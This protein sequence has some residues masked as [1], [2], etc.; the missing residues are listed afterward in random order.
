MRLY[1]VDYRDPRLN[2][3]RPSR[4]QERRSFKVRYDSPFVDIVFDTPYIIA[5]DGKNFDEDREKGNILTLTGSH[6]AGLASSSQR[7]L[8]F[9]MIGE[10]FA[11]E[12]YGTLQINLDVFDLPVFEQ[13]GEPLVPIPYP[14]SVGRINPFV[15]LEF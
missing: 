11:A 13:L 9:P 15:A 2:D 14:E 12:L 5:I 7:S 4:I 3:S 6:F 10:P 8:S 1:R